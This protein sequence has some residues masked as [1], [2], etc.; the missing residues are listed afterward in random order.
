MS[1]PR[2]ISY[3]VGSIVLLGVA[4][5]TTHAALLAEIGI[6]VEPAFDGGPPAT[7][8]ALYQFGALS[9]APTPVAGE[10]GRQV[11]ANDVGMTFETPPSIV[12]AFIQPL[13]RPQADI[14]IR[15]HRTEY[16]ASLAQLQSS[17]WEL[18]DRATFQ[19]FVPDITKVPVN[20]ITMTIDSFHFQR[21]GDNASIGGGHTIHIYGVPEP[22][23]WV[24]FIAGSLAGHSL[25]RL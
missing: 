5:G 21:F 17:G 22:A 15:V 24:L 12:N 13:T 1:R 14:S 25:M 10:W 19:K 23:T 6:N 16:G 18:G 4:A 3:V 11:S 2:L 7:D 9:L 20:R 8:T